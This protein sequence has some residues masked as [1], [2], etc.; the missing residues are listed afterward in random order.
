MRLALATNWWALVI[1]GMAGIIFG[2]LALL[3][4]GITLV[5]LIFIFAAYALVD[6]VAS[7]VGAV[8]AMGQHERWG[9]LVVEGI[10]GIATALITVFWPGITAL[11]LVYV[12]G[13]WAV[14]TGL[15]EITAAVRLRQIISGE[16]LLFLSGMA[17]LLFGFLVMIVPIAGALAIAIWVGIYSLVFGVMLTMLGFRM[18]SWGKSPTGAGGPIPAHAH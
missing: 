12:I 9:V 10:V 17:S 11:A 8:R 16:W 5:A 6:G 15:L 14:V 3:W 2:I 18:R 13:A 7:L 1:R 4:P